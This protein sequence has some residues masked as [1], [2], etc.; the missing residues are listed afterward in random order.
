MK[1]NII[2][3]AF[4]T[5]MLLMPSAVPSAYSA[6]DSDDPL[7][8]GLPDDVPQAKKKTAAKKASAKKT[9]AKKKTSAKKTVKKTAKKKT[10]YVD[11]YKFKTNEFESEPVS[12]KFNRAGNPIVSIKAGQSKTRT[13]GQDYSQVWKNRNQP[14]IKTKNSKNNSK[15]YAKPSEFDDNSRSSQSDEL[16]LPDG[17]GQPNGLIAV[18]PI[19]EQKDSRR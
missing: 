14:S 5:A 15:K 10:I 12:Y 7:V 19:I 8:E 1:K 16:T 11:E 2:L 17:L 4:L 9:T 6:D 18:D 13:F 3:T